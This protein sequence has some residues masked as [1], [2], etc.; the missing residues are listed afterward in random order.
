MS[1]GAPS[2]IVDHE[3]LGEVFPEG[4]VA[5]WRNGVPRQ[6]IPLAQMF[7]YPPVSLAQ[8]SAEAMSGFD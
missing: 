6:S 3:S 2:G 4:A 8:R 7:K 5:H 1:D